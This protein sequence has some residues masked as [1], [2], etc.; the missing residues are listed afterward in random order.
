MTEYNSN[1]I[2]IN[3]N[4]NNEESSII[5]DSIS[6][7]DTISEDKEPESGIQFNGEY[8][9]IT[10]T[11]TETNE[12]HNHFQTEESNATGSYDSPKE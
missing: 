2:I 10:E 1:P 9:I 6:T 7:I 4:N 8:R 11:G 3:H 5:G 12:T